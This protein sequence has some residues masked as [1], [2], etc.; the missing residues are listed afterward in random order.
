MTTITLLTNGDDVYNAGNGPDDVRGLNG[1]DIIFGGKGNDDLFGGNGNDTMNGGDGNDVLWG[2]PGSDRLL[3]GD[4]SD[5]FAFGSGSKVGTDVVRDFVDGEDYIH[6]SLAGFDFG[7]V[8]QSI[9]GA[10][11]NNVTIEAGAV[12]IHFRIIGGTILDATDFI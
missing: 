1:N 8:S 11:N 6:C 12:D 5:T 4:G 10:G 2:G 3:G 9:G 7:D